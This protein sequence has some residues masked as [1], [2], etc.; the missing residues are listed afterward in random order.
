[1]AATDVAI[2]SRALMLLGAG[3]ISSFEDATDRAKI[4][5]VAYPG[6]RDD[7][8][9]KHPW[10][11]RM[12]KKELTR[13]AVA[14][15]GEWKYSYIIPGEAMAGAPHALF[16]GPTG[17]LGQADYEIFERRVLT[18]H[19]RVLIDIVVDGSEGTWPPY[20]QQLVV[21]ALCAEIAFPITDQSGL[22]EYWYTRAFGTPSE[23]GRGG[24]YA[25]ATTIDAQGQGNI[26]FQSDAFTEARFGTA[27]AAVDFIWP[28]IA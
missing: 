9:S 25:T 2:C 3:A 7:L 16:Y 28:G 21:Y 1:M 6:L 18:N 12:R 17:R 20:F 22:A 19:E 15:I 5:K 14:P 23:E 24:A 10:R 13:D 26:G 4:V 11:W 27:G 8:I